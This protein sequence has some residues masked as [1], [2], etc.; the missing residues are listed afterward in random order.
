M[1]TE[2]ER[3]ADIDTICGLSSEKREQIVDKVLRAICGRDLLETI[4]LLSDGLRIYEAETYV[5]FLAEDGNSAR[6]QWNLSPILNALK[7]TV[8]VSRE[9]LRRPGAPP[10]RWVLAPEGRFFWER[11]GVGAP[12]SGDVFWTI[13]EKQGSR[14]RIYPFIGAQEQEPN[15]AAVVKEYGRVPAGV[16][17][18]LGPYDIRFIPPESFEPEAFDW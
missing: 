5:H 10:S 15:S 2:Q 18:Q 16:L 14:V 3:C 17:R 13:G 8:L 12:E 4:H 1:I 6:T 9:D 7:T 11:W